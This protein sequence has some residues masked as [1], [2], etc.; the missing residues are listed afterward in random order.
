M[1]ICNWGKQATNTHT[2]H[3]KNFM[4]EATYKDF[5]FQSTKWSYQCICLFNQSLTHDNVYYYPTETHWSGFM[6]KGM[7][8]PHSAMITI[9]Q[10]PTIIKSKSKS[11]QHTSNNTWIQ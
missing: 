9:E 10:Q 7:C 1:D 4:K 5:F 3:T 11:K 2:M 6:H 8:T